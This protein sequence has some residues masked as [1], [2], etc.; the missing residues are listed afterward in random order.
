MQT[1]RIKLITLDL[2]DTLWPCWPTIEA[3]EASLWRWMEVRAP[4]LAQAH[5]AM[6][7]H[8]QRKHYAQEQPHLAHDVTALR[9][10]VLKKLLVEFGYAA[11]LAG[12]ATAHF[13]AER[14][15]VQPYP[16]VVAALKSL[17]RHCHLASVTNGNAQ[18]SCTPLSGLFDLSLTAAEVGAMRPD[19][20]MLHA[21]CQHFGVRPEQA[22]HIGDD[23]ERDVEAARAIGMQ[24]VWLDRFD[25]RW[26]PDR[27][28]PG[29][30]LRELSDLL[31]YFEA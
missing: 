19:P 17:R 9:Y 22:L 30:I 25:R 6:S 13:N 4:R 29:L 24:T 31:R 16:D 2:D 18:I 1:D 23:L 5:N 27:T 20:A 8:E 3:A 11:E 7:L 14:Q 15:K 28:R 21:A 10:Q 26:P 12:Q